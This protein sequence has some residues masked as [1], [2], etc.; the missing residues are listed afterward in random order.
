MLK[1]LIEKI[2]IIH[3]KKLSRI[4]NNLKITSIIDVGSHFGEFIEPIVKN[5]KI[6]F[7]YMYE[8][9]KEAFK[10]LK[11]KFKNKKKFKLF[12]FALDKKSHS[13]KLYI[14][15]LSSSSTMTRYNQNSNYLK[16]K[17]YLLNT[18]KNYIK[19]YIVKTDTIDNHFK[20]KI[21]RNFLLKLDVEGSEYNVLLGAKKILT[22]VDY[23]IIE[24]Q[25]FNLYRTNSYKLSHKYLNK[26]GFKILQKITFPTLH[27]QDILY[28]N[29]NY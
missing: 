11:N 25:F 17:N 3:Y 26:I 23:I 16:F 6:K 28:I 7:F 1:F 24:K 20:N 22:K 10:I 12:N 15:K 2:S 19:S 4:I 9:Q 13:K 14:N 8:P 5:K 18:N 27:Y 21:T 29:K